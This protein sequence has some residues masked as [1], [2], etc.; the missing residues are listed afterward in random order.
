MKKYIVP[1]ADLVPGMFVTDLDRPWLGTPFLLQGFHVDGAD[2]IEELRRLCKVVTV[3]PA[4]SHCR[5]VDFTAYERDEQ[6]AKPHD[7]AEEPEVA[8]END[9]F[10]SAAYLVRNRKLPK[11]R[12]TPP[13]INPSDGQSQLVAEMIY[14]A[15]IVDDVQSVMNA[16]FASIESGVKPDFVELASLTMEMAQSVARN[17][18]ALLWLARLKE[19]DSYSYDHAIDVSVHMMVFASFLGYPQH[20]VESLGLA[21]MLQDIGKSEVDPILLQKTGALDDDERSQ[22]RA[23]VAS[24]LDML[25]KTAVFSP[26][27]FDI[28]ANHHERHDGSGY[29]RGIAGEVLSLHAGMAG[30]LDTYCA[31][32]RARPYSDG[33]S[34]QHVLEELNRMRGKAFRETLVDQFVQCIGLYPIGTLVDLNSGEVAVVIQ[35]NQ[36][37]RLQPKVMVLLGPDKSVERHPRTLDLLMQPKT[38]TGEAYRI[39][40]ALAGNAY[41]IDPRDYYLVA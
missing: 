11:G 39:V 8:I 5:R 4:R 33:L 12:G 2:Q 36:V 40:R 15:S 30:M 38:P 7:F 34:N 14:S 20:S 27:L 3:D 23:H 25:R 16:I 41:G 10:Y 35:Q 19:T 24:S 37:R 6:P 9:D 29:P 18:D 32:L 28:V 22:I 13:V 21:G 1:V 26:S 17:T 31:M